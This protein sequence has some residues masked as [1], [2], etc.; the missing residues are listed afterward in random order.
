MLGAVAKAARADAAS[1]AWPEPSELAKGNDAAFEQDQL[2]RYADTVSE[3]L[4]Q[5]R[6]NQATLTGNSDRQA[7][8]S[9]QIQD[10]GYRRRLSDLTKRLTTVQECLGNSYRVS[11]GLIGIELE[12]RESLA[13]VTAANAYLSHQSVFYGQESDGLERQLSEAKAKERELED[14]ER[15]LLTVISDRQG[16]IASLTQEL[17]TRESKLAAIESLFSDNRNAFAEKR[18]DLA[19]RGEVAM[20]QL[21]DLNRDEIEP[22]QRA[23]EQRKAEVQG[24][25]NIEPHLIG[26]ESDAQL[27]E[28]NLK[29]DSLYAERE[30]VQGALMTVREQMQAIDYEERVKTAE[31]KGASSGFQAVMEMLEQEEVKLEEDVAKLER[32]QPVVR[33][34]LDTAQKLEVLSG[35]VKVAVGEHNIEY[36]SGDNQVISLTALIKQ[37]RESQA[38]ERLAQAGMM[39]DSD[40]IHAQMLAT[41]KDLFPNPDKAVAALLRRWEVIQVRQARYNEELA[42]ASS[43]MEARLMALNKRLADEIDVAEAELNERE[44]PEQGIMGAAARLEGAVDLATAAKAEAQGAVEMARVADE[45]ARANAAAVKRALDAEDGDPRQ[46][47]GADS[48]KRHASYVM[49]VGTRPPPPPPEE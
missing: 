22:T 26:P 32:L 33:A 9:R 18:Q 37:L 25:L 44:N 7:A 10:I 47:S 16:S 28:L 27:G 3:Q 12:A 14:M 24:L 36:D 4:L 34:A 49:N 15:Q 41:V 39:Q 38:S 31:V 5:Q 29:L 42:R 46:M 1:S 23:Y 19:A 8:L 11:L 43:K 35:N 17:E 40:S 13:R 6:L 48:A 21:A 30:V 2:L 45:T 20:M